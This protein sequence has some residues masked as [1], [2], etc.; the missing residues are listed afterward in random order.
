MVGRQKL[1]FGKSSIGGNNGNGFFGDFVNIWDKLSNEFSGICSALAPWPSLLLSDSLELF[2]FS[3]DVELDGLWYRISSM[4][5]EDLNF[6][7]FIMLDAWPKPQIIHGS[8]LATPINSLAQNR[9]LSTN[10]FNSLE[11]YS[12]LFRKSIFSFP[13]QIQFKCKS[14]IPEMFSVPFSSIDWKL[15]YKN[16][17]II[18]KKKSTEIWWRKKIS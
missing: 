8:F 14:S 17:P 3:L 1:D 6:G 13:N 12:Q 10:S 18:L 2:V 11:F 16:V 9:K 15:V 4:A 5:N 7:V